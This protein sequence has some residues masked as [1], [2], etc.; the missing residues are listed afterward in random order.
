MCVER[1]RTCVCTCVC[2]EIEG[3]CT[4]REW[5]C[6]EIDVEGFNEA[7]DVNMKWTRL[8][9]AAHTPETARHRTK[10][11]GATSTGE[12][13]CEC[14]PRAAAADL[15]LPA[16][17]ALDGPV[18]RHAA[19]GAHVDVARACGV[20]NVDN[21]RAAVGRLLQVN[22]AGVDACARGDKGGE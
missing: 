3:V 13:R 5:A 21:L 8:G 20:D 9:M 22:G 16:G 14:V 17:E 2:I 11:S 7:K 10:T 19:D 12:K 4:S 6:V 18:L 15:E 1:V